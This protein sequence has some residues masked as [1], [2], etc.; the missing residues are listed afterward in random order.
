MNN[1]IR[2][3]G[4][5]ISRLGD[6]GSASAWIVVSLMGGALLGKLLG[7][8]REI[9]M[10]RI[11]GASVVADSFRASIT[12][13]QLP[14][15]PMLGES[16]PAVLIPMH[17]AWQDERRAPLMLSALSIV[18]GLTAGLLMLLVQLTGQWWVRVLVGGFSPPGPGGDVWPMRLCPAAPGRAPWQARPTWS[19]APARAAGEALDPLCLD[20]GQRGRRV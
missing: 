5:A 17:R 18:L 7:F 10:A 20:A 16:T 9:L 11:L 1:P 2:E 14:L 3:I 8:A 4:K 19:G 15:L 6:R 12:A 13:V